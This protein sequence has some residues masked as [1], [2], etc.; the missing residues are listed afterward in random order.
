MSI[1][2]L[3]LG[4]TGTR[5]GATMTFKVEMDK[6]RANLKILMEDYPKELARVMGEEC[7][8]IMEESVRIC[9]FDQDNQHKDGTPHLVETAD[10]VADIDVNKILFTLSYDTPYAVLQHEVQE[11]HHDKPEQWKY[12]EQPAMERVKVL[13]PNL[14]RGVDMELMMSGSYR[15][16]SWTALNEGLKKWATLNKAKARYG[17]QLGRFV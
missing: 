14:V 5:Y 2:S 13:A 10:I 8:A 3:T 6:V 16:Q 15:A 9:P 7:I 11:Y 17:N 12:L 4:P 1:T